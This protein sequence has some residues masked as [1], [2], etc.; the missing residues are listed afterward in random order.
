MGPAWR[1]NGM[2]MRNPMSRAPM[3]NNPMGVQSPTQPSY[4]P[5]VSFQRAAQNVLM[6]QPPGANTAMRPL[7]MP[8]MQFDANQNAMVRSPRQPLNTPMSGNDFGL[9]APS[10]PNVGVSQESIDSRNMNTRISRLARARGVR[11]GDVALWRSQSPAAQAI[12]KGYGTSRES[13][14]PPGG[15]PVEMGPSMLA[16]PTPI[17]NLAAPQSSEPVKTVGQL[18]GGQPSIGD[19]A[20]FMPRTGMAP[21]RTNSVPAGFIQGSNGVNNVNR[22]QQRVPQNPGMES[23]SP[24]SWRN[25]LASRFPN[26][27][28]QMFAGS[29]SVLPAMGGFNP[30]QT[31]PTPT[32]QQQ[33]M[34]P[35]DQFVARGTPQA[36]ID[37]ALAEAEAARRRQSTFGSLSNPGFGR[38]WR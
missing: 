31:N 37:G 6:Q 17:P 26:A 16:G 27:V 36:Q 14:G 24:V 28:P 12:M 4:A 38:P 5:N 22:F 9:N 2:S 33:A 21:F 23:E 7:N 32:I 10:R 3:N 34:E 29:L 8:G 13:Q 1:N 15:R 19:T 30:Y 35:R 11:G 18:V 25:P 20:K